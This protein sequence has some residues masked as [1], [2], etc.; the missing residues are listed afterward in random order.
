MITFSIVTITFN[1]EKVLNRTLES[2]F[3][4]SYPHIEHI[5]I[6]GASSDGTLACVKEY[7]KRSSLNSNEKKKKICS[8]PDDGLYYAMN[9]G[10]SQATGDYICFL[11]A[12]DKLHF[13]DTLETIVANAELDDTQAAHLPLPAV[14]YG[15]TDIVD[16]DGTFLFKR[17]LSPPEQLNWRSFKYGMLVCHQA[18][19]A[20]RDIAQATQYDI[21]YKY[22]ADVDWC[23]RIMK[24]A[25]EQNLTLKNLHTTVVDYMQEGM[26]TKNHKK[27]LRERYC[28][29]KKYYG[30]TTTIF[31]HL[32]FIF[33]SAFSK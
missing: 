9:K 4:Q 22:S 6:D 14:L 17:R 10:L 20:R 5:I 23:I 8:E 19:Y 25:E 33:R 28:I 32:Y 31:M 27:S 16:G 12:G 30:S 11:N 7:M 15:E 2:V 18:F 3:N 24:K 26:T 13:A 1:A 21:K 29:M